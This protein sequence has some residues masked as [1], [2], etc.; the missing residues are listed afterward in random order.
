MPI[1]CALAF[2]FVDLPLR[3]TPPITAVR[4]GSTAQR[5]PLPM[6]KTSA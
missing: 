3:G 6:P 4:R 2:S 5:N 1:G